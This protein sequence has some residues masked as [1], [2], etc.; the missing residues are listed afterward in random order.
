MRA[1]HTVTTVVVLG[2][3]IYAVGSFAAIS[4]VLKPEPK[5]AEPPPK[6]LEEAA[7]EVVALR[8]GMRKLAMEALSQV[9]LCVNR[10]EE[11]DPARP[12][13]RVLIWDVEKDD[14]SEAHGRLPAELRLQSLDQPCTVYL[15]T[16]RERTHVMDY[17][18]DIFR[19]GGD[20]GVQGFRTDLFVCAVDLPSRQP[21]GRYRLNGNGPP[22]LVELKPGVKE[23]DENWAGNLK[24]WIDTCVKGPEARYVATY[25]QAICRHAD[26]ARKV[27]GECELIGSLPTLGKFPRQAMIYNLQTDRWHRASGF[28]RGRADA[29]AEEMLLVLPLE[30]KVVIDQRTR[31]GRIDTRV[32]LV[33][34]P[35]A[36]PM[37][38]YMVQGQAWS[39]PKLA[40]DSWWQE[41]DSS[42]RRDPN[43]A[44]ARWV[45]ELC[46]VKRGL[47]KGTLA[48]SADAEPLADSEWL[49]GPGWLK[50][51]KRDPLPANQQ[52]W[53]KMAEACSDKVKQCRALGP[54]APPARLP[55]KIVVWMDHSETFLPSP[56]QKRLPTLLQ[57]GATDT[58]VLVALIVGSELVQEPRGAM[59]PKTERWEHDLALFTMPGATPVGVYRV[60]G[61]SLACDR[62]RIG[63]NVRNPDTNKEVA[64]WLVRFMASPQSVARE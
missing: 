28:V 56:A 36:E 17:S 43:Q 6:P 5:V 50:R 62:L 35:N 14:V 33:A 29:G 64:D 55:K 26:E 32:A 48:V 38:V 8:G 7:P 40:S 51:M 23:I 15:I 10:H 22:T 47:P 44:L 57:A 21:R 52:G 11:D 39:I 4:T 9:S 25:D 20:A 42:A 16:E 30:E 12:R 27:I 54:E 24:R 49:K 31:L 41:K 19:G 13:G 53:E 18:Y 1:I 61:E 58:D 34:F 45:E 3:V 2:L 59:R 37:G 63:R 46:K 60:Q